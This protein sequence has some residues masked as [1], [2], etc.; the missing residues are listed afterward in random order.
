MSMVIDSISD[1]MTVHNHAHEI[2]VVDRSCMNSEGGEIHPVRETEK[3][4]DR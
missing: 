4:R 1:S 3:K 2:V